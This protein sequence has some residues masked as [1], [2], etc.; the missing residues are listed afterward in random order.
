[1]TSRLARLLIVALVPFPLVACHSDYVIR[2]PNGYFLARVTSKENV[3]AEPGGKAVIGPT[4]D[5]YAIKGDVVVGSSVRNDDRSW[6]IL[7]T[8]LRQIRNVSYSEW[9]NELRTLDLRES[10]VVAPS[11]L[12]ALMQ[13]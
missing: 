10:D 12:Q 4:V 2:L 7:D 1:M 6:F 3:V 8:R 11:R 13:R 5:K 9:K